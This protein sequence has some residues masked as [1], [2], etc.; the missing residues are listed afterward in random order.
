MCCMHTIRSHFG[1]RVSATANPISERSLE[2][3]EKVASMASS[4]GK[5]GLQSPPSSAAGDRLRLPGEAV[6]TSRKI[7][8]LSLLKKKLLAN[9]EFLDNNE[10][11]RKGIQISLRNRLTVQDVGQLLKGC[12]KELIKQKEAFIEEK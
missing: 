5:A 9:C 2:A 12:I 1:S 6:Q 8:W 7:A 10:E 3:S 4:L 11:L